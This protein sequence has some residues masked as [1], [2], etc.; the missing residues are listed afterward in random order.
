MPTR[1]FSRGRTRRPRRRLEWAD[2]QGD[3]TSLPIGSAMV[4]DQLATFAALPGADIAGATVVRIHSRLWIT[5]SVVV[6]D[7][8]SWSFIVANNN[9]ATAGA[10]VPLSSPRALNP[11]FQPQAD[12]LMYQKFNAHPNYSFTG[13]GANLE[14]DIKSRRRL[15]ELDETLLMIVE[16]IDAS[17]AINFSWHTRALLALA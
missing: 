16:N 2:S 14:L 8:I 12:W 5:S 9:Q 6:G 11:T 3:V 7:G 4:I 1:H 17:A 13:G 15:P 10:G